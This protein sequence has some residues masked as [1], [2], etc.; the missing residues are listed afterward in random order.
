MMGGDSALGWCWR[1]L[2]S[3]LSGPGIE[4]E[5]RMREGFRLIRDSKEIARF[6]TGGLE[7]CAEHVDRA[8][9]HFEV[10]LRQDYEREERS[11][12]KAY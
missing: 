1:M 10:S 4:L 7:L 12:R 5:Y 11:L 2:E 3:A 8:R 9:I 6:N